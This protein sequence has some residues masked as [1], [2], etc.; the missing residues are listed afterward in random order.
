M[1]YK[2]ATFFCG[3]CHYFTEIF[4]RG[5]ADLRH[6]SPFKETNLKSYFISFSDA[7][8]LST[9][10]DPDHLAT[11]FRESAQRPCHDTYVSRELFIQR[12]TCTTGVVAAH[13][14]IQELLEAILQLFPSA[15]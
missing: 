13:L 7:H 8:C 2:L 3:C 1:A 5:Q 9:S 10:A 15:G 14:L 4:P 12:Q 6:N 11:R